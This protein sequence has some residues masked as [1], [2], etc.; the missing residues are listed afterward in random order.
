MDG[1][2][3]R[4]RRNPTRMCVNGRK[5][6]EELQRVPN[7]ASARIPTPTTEGYRADA[8]VRGGGN[9]FGSG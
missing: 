1:A 6:M 8:F 9:H 3:A 5:W 2:T 7:V 4:P